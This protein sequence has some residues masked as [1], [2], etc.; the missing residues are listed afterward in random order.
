MSGGPLSDRVHR[1]RVAGVGL[2]DYLA[3]QVLERQAPEVQ[4]F[5]LRTSLLEEF[6]ADLCAEV[7]GQALNIDDDWFELVS[8]ILR[9]NLFIQQIGED[10]IWLRYHHLFRDFLVDRMQ[11]THPEESRLIELSQATAWMR[12]GE[13]ERAYEVYSKS[14]T[15]AELAQLVEQA[16]PALIARG[17]LSLLNDWLE[18]LPIAERIERPELI[19]LQAGVA[20]VRGSPQDSL[21][22]LDEAEQLFLRRGENNGLSQ[23]LTRRSDA[24]RL[25]G[26]Y[27]VSIEDARKALELAESQDTYNIAADALLCI[28]TSQYYLGELQEAWQTLEQGRRVFLKMED[29]EGAAKVSMLLGMVAN[30][31]GLYS[32]GEKA[33]AEALRYY[34]TTGNRIL[35]SNILNNLGVVQHQKG[36]YEA[37]ASSFER[38]IHYAQAGNY[39]RLEAYALTSIGDLYRDVGALEESLEAYRQA[40]PVGLRSNERFLLFYLDLAEGILSYL[41]G[42]PDKA[43]RL[44]HLAWQAAE[45]SGSHYQQ[46]LVRMERGAACLLLNQTREARENLR[47]AVSYFEQAGYRSELLRAR[48]FLASACFSSDEKAESTEHLNHVYAALTDPGNHNLLASVGLQLQEFLKNAT[49]GTESEAAASSLLQHVQLF[50]KKLPSLRRQLRRQTQTVPFGPPR[51]TI[52]T[53]GRVQ[54]KVNNKVVNNTDWVTET[55]RDLFLM[56]AAHP[57]GMTKEEAGAVLWPE[58]SNDELKWRFKNTIYRLRRAVGKDVILFDEETD[59]YR[60]NHALDYDEDAETF[61][62]TIEL[63]KNSADIQRRISQFESAAKLYRGDYLSDLDMGWVNARRTH[64]REKYL[65]IMLD[66]ARLY[67]EINQTDKALDTIDRALRTDRC[68][69]EAYQL[70]MQIHAAGENLAGVKRAYEQCRTTL[71]EEM[72]IQ[73]DKSTRQLFDSL[74]H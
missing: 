66:L 37:A 24:N 35:Q 13:W 74:N 28:G 62:R 60:F 56:L 49:V 72:G 30:A 69:E 46:N 50:E 38:A 55:S 64:L 73:P 8:T 40:R 41:E 67:F 21:R 26:H 4:Q 54:V 51:I 27:A 6:D 44:L 52:H 58:S 71:A 19:S 22:M 7:I 47:E 48:F 42:Q 9:L 53:L 2:Y 10:R 20:I 11:R 29:E 12:R 25:L 63:A 31:L 34:E 23:L 5:L 65:D 16:G 3:Q 33:Y 68:F 36:G 14:A 17:R 70:S 15:P 43:L 57:E 59:I 61:E 45:I 1:A 32:Q 18:T 39:A